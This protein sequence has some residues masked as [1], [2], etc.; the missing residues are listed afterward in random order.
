M[1]K[2]LDQYPNSGYTITTGVD[3]S[4]LV[5]CP[6]HGDFSVSETNFRYLR[7]CMMCRGVHPRAYPLQ[8]TRKWCANPVFINGDETVS[9]EPKSPIYGVGYSDK[10]V[11]DIVFKLVNQLGHKDGKILHYELDFARKVMQSA[12]TFRVLPH[13]LKKPNK[14]RFCHV[15]VEKI[16]DEFFRVV[17]PNNFIGNSRHGT[18]FRNRLT[19]ELVT[20]I[21]SRL[22]EYTGILE[23]KHLTAVDEI[24]SAL[25][26]LPAR[27]RR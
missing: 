22:G 8:S 23:E 3:G 7:G 27:F 24:F 19:A 10:R 21:I 17:G 26:Y 11:A 12:A 25:Q 6:M 4:L 18:F 13:H 16:D 14:V 9:K 2:Y 20:H 5:T 15:H 1:E